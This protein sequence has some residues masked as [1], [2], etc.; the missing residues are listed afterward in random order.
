MPKT[1]LSELMR[2]TKEE[3]EVGFSFSEAES[4]VIFGLD[5]ATLSSRVIEG[6]FPDFEKIIPKESAYKINVD[7]EEML[8]AVRLASVFARDAANAPGVF[9]D[10]PDPNFL[11]L[12]MPVRTQS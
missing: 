9:T 12:I 3:E 10:P 11:H 4:Q 7:K 8:R 6:E 1:A 5:D 2:L